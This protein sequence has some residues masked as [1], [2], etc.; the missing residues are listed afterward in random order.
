MIF[1]IDSGRW[2]ATLSRYSGLC[3]S[4]DTTLM[5]ERGCIPARGR[6]AGR[7]LLRDPQGGKHAPNRKRRGGGT[8]TKEDV[9]P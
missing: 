4:D 7:S 9:P 2:I 8:P 5:R 3:I 6:R 1:S